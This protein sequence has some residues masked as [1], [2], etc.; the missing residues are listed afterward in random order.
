VTVDVTEAPAEIRISP[1]LARK[2][3]TI[4]VKY[5]ECDEACESYAACHPLGVVEG[6]KYIITDVLEADQVA[7]RIGPSPVLVRIVPL[8]DGLPRYSQ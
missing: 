2:N 4:I 7:C 6:Q 5:P 3:T 8:P 1:E